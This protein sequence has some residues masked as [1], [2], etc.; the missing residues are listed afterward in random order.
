[1]LNNTLSP[2]VQMQYMR[3][4]LLQEALG[5]EARRLLLSLPEKERSS[6]LSEIN[7]ESWWMI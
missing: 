6:T 3:P 2:T 5:R 7:P 4:R 1:M